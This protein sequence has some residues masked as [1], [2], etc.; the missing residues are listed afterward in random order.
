M[1]R[2]ICENCQ[3]EKSAKYLFFTLFNGGLESR[4]ILSVPE[5]IDPVFVKTSPKRSF[6]MAKNE[7]FRLVFAKTMSINSGTV[8]FSGLTN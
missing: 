1:Y 6:S 8:F 2:E 3:K 5:F 4:R 7:R